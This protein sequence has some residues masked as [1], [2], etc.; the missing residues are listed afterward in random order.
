[1]LSYKLISPGARNVFDVPVAGP[2]AIFVR[3]NKGTGTT[4]TLL[5]ATLAVGAV[6]ALGLTL[7]TSVRRRRTWPS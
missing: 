2:N 6:E 4:P 5:G 7:I 1:L 3:L